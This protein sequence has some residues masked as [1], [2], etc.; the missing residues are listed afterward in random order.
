LLDSGAMPVTEPI[1]RLGKEECCPMVRIGVVVPQQ[2]SDFSRMRAAWI[3]ADE[4]GV[5]TLHLWD[6]F[7]PITGNPKGAGFEAMALL[8][9]MAEVT[10][11]FEFGA[12]VLC[13]SYRN[14]HLVADAARTIDHMSGGRYTLGPGAGWF[15]KGQRRVRARVRHRWR[16]AA[17]PRR[18]RTD[19]QGEARAAEPAARAPRAH[20]D[21]RG[22]RTGHPAYRRPPCRHLE[23]LALQ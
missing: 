3:K 7:Y 4:L 22:T 5:D 15:R 18:R 13:N 9:A 11:R 14:P 1:F 10:H 2:H 8:S 17:G 6:H 20:P 21:Q 23:I 19:H 16:P 12:L